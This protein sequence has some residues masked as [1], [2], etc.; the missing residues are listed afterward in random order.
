DREGDPR[1]SA[2]LVECL[3]EPGIEPWPAGDRERVL[4]DPLVVGRGAQAVAVPLL[5][6]FEPDPLPHKRW[7]RH[8]HRWT[9]CRPRLP[10]GAKRENGRCLRHRFGYHADMVYYDHAMVGATLA[11]A[12]GA[13]RR[14]GW[15]VVL[16]AA[17]VG[18]FPDWDALSKHVSPQT[19]KVG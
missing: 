19:Y 14:Y 9:S 16:L 6:R 12:V 4:P 11:V 13:Q 17:L 5:Q 10:Y 1:A 3:V 8:R 18:M 15:G 7:C 2:Q